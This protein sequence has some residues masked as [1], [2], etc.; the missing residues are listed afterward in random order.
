MSGLRCSGAKQQNHMGCDRF[1]ETFGEAYVLV[2]LVRPKFPN[3]LR[4][5]K[6]FL[7]FSNGSE[8]PIYNVLHG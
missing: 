5:S 7:Y 3:A 4:Q 8:E 6:S 1:D 2:I